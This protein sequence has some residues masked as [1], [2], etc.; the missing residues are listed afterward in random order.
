MQI[1]LES[2]EAGDEVR[3]LPCFHFFHSECIDQCLVTKKTCPICRTSIRAQC[4]EAEAADEEM[5]AAA[6]ADEEGGAV[7]AGTEEA[8]EEV[9][10]EAD[11]EGGAAGVVAAHG[12]PGALFADMAPFGDACLADTAGGEPLSGGDEDGESG[13]PSAVRPPPAR[14][15]CASAA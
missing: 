14:S 12:A 9:E 3:T 15:H 4:P 1:C 7:V 8:M 5:V 11:A 6:A 2:Y 10:A 13:T